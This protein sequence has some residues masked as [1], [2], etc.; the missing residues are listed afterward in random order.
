MPSKLKAGGVFPYMLKDDR[1]DKTSC[2][3]QLRVLSCMEEEELRLAR[4]RYFQRGDSDASE[5]VMLKEMLDIAVVGH[6]IPG[7]SD[8]R[9]E[10]TSAECFE[11]VAGAIGG[12]VLTAEERKKFVW[13]PTS[14][15]GCSADAEQLAVTA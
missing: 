14:E 2:V 9:T 6:N 11:L 4:D 12:S 5:A 1:D 3:F 15:L 8:L 10:L 13:Q 7:V